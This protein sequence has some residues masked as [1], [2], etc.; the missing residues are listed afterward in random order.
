MMSSSFPFA[1]DDSRPVLPLFGDFRQHTAHHAGRGHEAVAL[2]FEDSNLTAPH[3]LA[4]P[5]HILYGHPRVLG[6]MLNN[7]R[8]CDV[9]IAKADGLPTLKA[10]QEVNRRVGI[11]RGELPNPV[12]KPSVI[13]NLS[14]TI[15]FGGLGTGTK[16]RI[17]S[18]VGS[19]SNG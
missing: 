15:F 1:L 19:L 9:D 4:K 16:G 7:H 10:D 3:G 17:A 14:L 8:S 13:V 18:S 5:L 11:G 6:T 12:G 2:A